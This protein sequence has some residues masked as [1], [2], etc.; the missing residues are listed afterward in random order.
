MTSQDTSKRGAPR[1]GAKKESAAPRGRGRGGRGDGRRP[2][3]EAPRPELD[4]K[5]ISIRRVTRVVAGGRRFSFSVALVAGDRNGSV[6]VG[7]GKAGDTTLA[8]Q[9]AYQNAK[10]NLV[11]IK[12]TDNNSIP[13]EVQVKEKSARVFLMPNKG[14]GV[15]VGSA[16]RTVIELAGLTDITGRVLSKSKN[17]LNIARATIKALE[18]FVIA[19][20]AQALPASKQQRESFVQ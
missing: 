15:V 8:I 4:Q 1:G 6:G 7:I 5:M 14:R 20:G 3:Q 19:R 12:R 16:M 9:K 10:K 13:Q 17:K 18:P 11:R 2:H